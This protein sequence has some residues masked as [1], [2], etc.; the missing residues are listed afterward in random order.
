MDYIEKRLEEMEKEI[1]KMKDLLK[2]RQTQNA[3]IHP[4]KKPVSFRGIAKL[5]VSKEELDEEIKKAKKSL[6]KHVS[7]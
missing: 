7:D 5:K 1:K 4:K 3:S 2:D 6:F